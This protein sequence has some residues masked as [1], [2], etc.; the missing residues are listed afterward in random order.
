MPLGVKARPHRADL[1]LRR[2]DALVGDDGQMVIIAP[3]WT[4]ATTP[5]AARLPRCGEVG[6]AFQV[7]GAIARRGLLALATEGL[8]L[9]LPLLTPELFD[10]LFQRGDA[11]DGL[12]MHAL[13]VAG[14]LTQF[15]TLTPQSSHLGTQGNHFLAAL[16]DQLQRCSQATGICDR[17]EEKSFHDLLVLVSN[18][19]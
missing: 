13:P 1:L 8:R 9:Q 16:G 3:F 17:F 5:L 18:G 6:L 15:E 11:S 19:G 14:L 12:G 4:A 2:Q 10:F 7:I